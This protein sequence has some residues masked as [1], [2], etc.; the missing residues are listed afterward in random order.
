MAMETL[1]IYDAIHYLKGELRD[2][3]GNTDR[4]RINTL[5]HYLKNFVHNDK[6]P[7][8]GVVEMLYSD[9]SLKDGAEAFKY[10]RHIINN[11]AKE[12]NL[13]FE[14]KTDSKTR[15]NIKD[16]YFYFV[17]NSKI[18]ESANEYAKEA[19]GD[20]KKL[21]LLKQKE[22]LL[23]VNLLLHFLSLVLIKIKK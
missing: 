9:K 15:S 12:L 10:F 2:S 20:V 6:A 11:K 7:L 22:F 18:E 4:E 21:S 5:S 1:K 3:L 23:P 8:Q 13:E 14:I 19:T 16:R 17:G